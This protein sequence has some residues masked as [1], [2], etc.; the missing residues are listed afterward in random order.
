MQCY[1]VA[2]V[3][4]SAFLKLSLFDTMILGVLNSMAIFHVNSCASVLNDTV[5]LFALYYKKLLKSYE[6]LNTVVQKLC[7]TENISLIKKFK[8]RYFRGCMTSL[9]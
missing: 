4:Q 1:N 3:F 7:S 5:Q 6:I 8:V 9:P 2:N